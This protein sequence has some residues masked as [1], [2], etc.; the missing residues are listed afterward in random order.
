MET[1]WIKSPEPVR[2]FLGFPP[3]KKSG[4]GPDLARLDDQQRA[5]LRPILG[6]LYPDENEGQ[7]EG[8]RK[9]AKDDPV[10]LPEVA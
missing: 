10:P 8:V 7:K 6:I 3:Q 9:E 2:S 1:I 4:P 5:Q